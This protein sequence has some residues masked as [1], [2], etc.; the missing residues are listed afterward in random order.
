MQTATKVK[1]EVDEDQESMVSTAVPSDGAS[2]ASSTSAGS[3][4]PGWGVLAVPGTAAPATPSV[5]ES[6]K[7]PRKA[8]SARAQLKKSEKPVSK[9]FGP[10]PV[11]LKQPDDLQVRF[12]SG[13]VACWNGEQY[14]HFSFVTITDRIIA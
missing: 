9:K 11:C 13:L 10:C 6:P 2:R 8:S 3:R 5:P 1:S 4:V 12:L 7:G 14:E